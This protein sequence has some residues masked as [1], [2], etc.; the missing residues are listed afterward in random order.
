MKQSNR[1]FL[2]LL[3]IFLNSS[4]RNL[5]LEKKTNSL[6]FVTLN[7]FAFFKLFF[8]WSGSR[9]KIIGTVQRFFFRFEGFF[10]SSRL[11]SK[12]S[13]RRKASEKKFAGLET[14]KLDR[15]KIVSVS[16]KIGLFGK[17]LRSSGLWLLGR[18]SV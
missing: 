16:E 5:N 12:A 10:Q 7:F 17:K 9:K 1:N 2:T 3:A 6:F 13:N 14:E 11:Q 8:N 4:Q 15:N 18:E